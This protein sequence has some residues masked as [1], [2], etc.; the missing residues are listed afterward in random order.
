M[1]RNSFKNA[2]RRLV[3][4]LTAAAL[5]V[6][7]VHSHFPEGK[8]Y[9]QSWGFVLAHPLLLLHVVVGTII[10]AEGSIL[11]VRCL[12][13]RNRSWVILASTGLAFALLAYV[14]GERYVATQ[15]SASITFMDLGWLGAL[16]TYGLGWYLGRKET[17]ASPIEA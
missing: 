16:V 12:R 2:A 4:E 1:D 5:L 15:R 17:P 3:I 10:L 7:I 6:G 11:L 14:S 9:A 8:P 13:R